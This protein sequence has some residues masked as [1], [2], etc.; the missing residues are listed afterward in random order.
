M[1]LPSQAF[2]PKVFFTSKEGTTLASH[3]FR[4]RHTKVI[5]GGVIPNRYLTPPGTNNR[6]AMITETT[7]DSEKEHIENNSKKPD[8]QH[9]AKVEQYLTQL[10]PTNTEEEE[11][12]TDHGQEICQHESRD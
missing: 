3:P 12:D 8:Q 4:T 10:A 1:L 2:R 6:N 5:I 7:N 11:T 9:Q